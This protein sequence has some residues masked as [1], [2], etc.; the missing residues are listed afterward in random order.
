MPLAV[1]GMVHA[2]P[3]RSTFAEVIEEPTA[4]R[5]FDRSPFGSCH[6]DDLAADERTVVVPLCAE[7][8]PRTQ[9]TAPAG[10]RSAKKSSQIPASRRSVRRIIHPILP[11]ERRSGI[12][13]AAHPLREAR[14]RDDPMGRCGPPRPHRRRRPRRQ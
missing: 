3:S 10:T 1:S 12:G 6:V 11:S 7:E 2:T 13:S 14:S 8:R 5:V 4:L 9:P